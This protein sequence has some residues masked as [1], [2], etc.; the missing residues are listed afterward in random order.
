MKVAKKK[1]TVEVSAIPT[2]TVEAGS[3]GKL[4]PR[5]PCITMKMMREAAELSKKGLMPEGIAAH[6][7]KSV[8]WVKGSLL[9]VKNLPEKVHMM[10]EDHRLSRIAALQLL[11][12]PADRLDS[13]LDSLMQLSETEG[14]L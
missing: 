10:I 5:P 4:V 1:K 8:G 7:E 6:M 12:C 9:I 14:K 11:L 2:V 3:G 13:V